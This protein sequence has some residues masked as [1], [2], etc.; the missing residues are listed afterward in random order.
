MKILG[1]T[2]IRADYD[3][4]SGLY[5]HLNEE[6]NVEF[7]LIV[8]GAHLAGDYGLSIQNILNDGFDILIEIET[9]LSSDSKKSKLKSASILLQN[10]IDI[11][12]QFSPDLI[13]FAGDREDVIVTAMLGVFLKI[14]TIHFYGG[15][16]EKGGHED[17]LI[18]HATSKLASL[19]FVSCSEHKNRLLAMGENEKRIF[20]IGSIALDKFKKFNLTS[21]R[22]M[23]LRLNKP[24]D[25][26]IALVIYHPSP[27]N[28]EN[29]IGHLVLNRIVD[30]VLEQ[31]L[32]AFVSSP[33]T[34]SG[35]K[36]IL[37]AIKLKSQDNNVVFF[38][39]LDRDTFLS[40]FAQSEFIIGNSS[41][42][43]LESS[44][45]PIPAINVGFRQ[46]ERMTSNN[47]IFCSVEKHDIVDAITKA[48][49]YKFIDSIKALRNPY[50]D[51]F[52]VPRAVELIKNL[53]LK[54]YLLKIED[55]LYD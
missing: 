42:G 45:I 26:K 16:H 40:V 8:S 19:H 14:P 15:D 54:E 33:N 11:V 2:S 48:M 44:S 4:M 23:L 17:T 30:S 10:S 12:E 47:V 35:N 41:A 29:E 21:T 5:K 1:F 53:N 49:S 25:K 34:D 27:E 32:I 9:L 13:I 50:G 3:L 22:S 38:N 52:S 55:P 31:G 24:I 51:G 36:Q 18:R 43:L 6:P 37:D 7:K 20:N 28:G 46:Q 39:N